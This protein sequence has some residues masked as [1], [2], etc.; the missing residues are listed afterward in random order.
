MEYTNDEMNELSYDL[1]IKY[2]KRTYVIYY[3]SLL[4]TK[5]NFIL[6]FFNNNDYNSKIIKIDLFFISFAIYYAVNAPF[7]NDDLLTKINEKY[8]K[9]YL[10]ILQII[11]S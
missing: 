2:D 7:F 8:G 9:F 4:K 3:C 10:N 1:A 5:H 11:Y 6:T